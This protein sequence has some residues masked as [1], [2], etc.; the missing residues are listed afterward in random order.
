MRHLTPISGD[1][2][3]QVTRIVGVVNG[4]SVRA[5]VAGEV[6]VGVVLVGEGVGAGENG[7]KKMLN[8][9]D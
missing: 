7:V 5:G 4:A 1:S 2:F 9:G 8:S 3:Q 6:A